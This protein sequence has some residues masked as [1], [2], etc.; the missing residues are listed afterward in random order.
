MAHGG[1]TSV[2]VSSEHSE[3]SCVR[4]GYALA[5]QLGTWGGQSPGLDSSSPPADTKV[6][7]VIGQGFSLAWV[8]VKKP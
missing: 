2:P 3:F 8:G 5:E 6:T 7:K 4:Q 1:E